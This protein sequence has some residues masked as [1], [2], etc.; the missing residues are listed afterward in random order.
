MFFVPEKLPELF[1]AGS[2][3]AGDCGDRKNV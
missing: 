2:S 1:E 3:S